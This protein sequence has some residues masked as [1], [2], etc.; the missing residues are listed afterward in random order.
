[1]VLAM[2]IG[3]PLVPSKKTLVSAMVDLL[4]IKKGDRVYDLG[5]G[6]GRLLIE[7]AKR[8]GVG[9]GIEINPYA[10]LWSYWN[11]WRSGVWGQVHIRW[12]N[13]WW[14]RLKNADSVIV[15]AMPG[16]MQK[17]SNKFKNELKPGTKI[18]SNLFQIPNLKEVKKVTLGKDRLYLYKV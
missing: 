4:K 11:I 3:A 6:D 13:Y 15:Y 10:I 8:G 18:V 2:F 7:V 12:G 1:M 9:Y 16:F 14:L 5:S 17:M